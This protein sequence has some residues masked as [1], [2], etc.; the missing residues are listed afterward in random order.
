MPRRQ[1][2]RAAERATSGRRHTGDNLPR[3]GISL[4]VA[5]LQ[6][7]AWGHHYLSQMTDM[8]WLRHPNS[9]ITDDGY[10][11]Y[12]GLLAFSLIETPTPLG[13]SLEAQRVGRCL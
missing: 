4:T 10:D 12:D 1:A 3:Q 13:E 2:A 7:L 6:G 5:L 11:R 9:A 8:T